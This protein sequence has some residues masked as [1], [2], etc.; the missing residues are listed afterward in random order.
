MEFVMLCQSVTEE[1]LP[2]WMAGAS[3]G[4]STT[5]YLSEKLDG[6]RCIWDGGVTR[7]MLVRDVPWANQYHGGHEI[8]TGYWSRLGN[9]IRAP[10]GDLGPYILDGELYGP[11]ARQVLMSRIKGLAPS[12]EGVEYKLYDVIPPSHWYTSRVVRW[13][14]R[15]HSIDFGKWRVPVPPLRPG[16]MAPLEERLACF[17]SQWRAIDSRVSLHEQSIVRTVEDVTARLEHVITS[18]GEGVVLKRGAYSCTRS[19]NCIKMKPYSDDEALLI[20]YTAGEGKYTGM[21]GAYRV[22]WKGTELQLS[23]MTDDERR[24]PPPIGTTVSFRY[25]GLSLGGVPQEARYWRVRTDD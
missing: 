18:G 8:S 12:F 9:V 5:C 15:K 22:L 10:Y 7:G 25:R 11:M 13:Q 2:A 3:R 20:G 16:Y 17:N 19:N 24:N 14:G 4:G 1:T 21:I 23:G 6:Q